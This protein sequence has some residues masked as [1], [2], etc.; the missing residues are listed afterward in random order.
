[1]LRAV[2]VAAGTASTTPGAQRLDMQLPEGQK[3]LVQFR[4]I[5]CPAL[6]DRGA[7]KYILTRRD[8]RGRGVV[9]R[10]LYGARRGAACDRADHVNIRVPMRGGR[11]S[12]TRS[13]GQEV[14]RASNAFASAGSRRGELWFVRS[15]ELA[16]DFSRGAR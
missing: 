1:M 11:A 4:S 15:A 10:S 6:A 3:P 7:M 16:G 14:S 13:F 8:D 9:R 2:W 12:S 5:W